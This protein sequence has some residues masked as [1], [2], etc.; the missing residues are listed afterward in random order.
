MPG[1]FVFRP[2]EANL[3]HS[4][5]WFGKMN[6]Y[7]VFLLDNNHINSQVCEN[8][9]RNPHW[10]D[11]IT[12]QTQNKSNLL[13]EVKDKG[14]LASDD[15]IGFCLIDLNEIESQGQVSKWYPL[16]YKKKHAGD[17]LLRTDFLFQR[18]KTLNEPTLGSEIQTNQ[19]NTL[20]QPYSTEHLTGF[21]AQGSELHHSQFVPDESHKIVEQRQRVEPRTFFKENEFVETRPVAKQ[22]QVLE[23]HKILKDVPYTTAVPIKKQIETLEPRLIKKDVE[24]MEPRVITKEIQVIENVPVMRKIEVIENVPV[25][26]EVEAIEPRTYTKQVEVTELFPVK[27]QVTI[28]EPVTLKRPIQFVEPLYTT[29]TVTKESRPTIIVDQKVTTEVGPPSIVGESEIGRNIQSEQFKTM[30]ISE[31]PR[32]SYLQ[33]TEYPKFYQQTNLERSNLNTNLY[34]KNLDSQQGNYIYPTGTRNLERRNFL[35]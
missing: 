31:V 18:G 25:M 3:S 21:R 13:M 10:S 23:P 22:I 20:Q 33:Q 9:G 17:I 4:T 2:I 19:I 16:Y 24:V 34:T 5:N 6:P 35:Y 28:T 7:C 11:T 32:I 30:N 27:K 26:T 8:G 29:K 12:I 1:T 14:V 15:S